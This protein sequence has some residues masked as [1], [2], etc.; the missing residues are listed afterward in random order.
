MEEGLNHAD[1]F[2]HKGLKMLYEG[3]R[4]YTVNITYTTTF[5]MMQ[6]CFDSFIFTTNASIYIYPSITYPCID[7]YIYIHPSP[8][9]ALFHIYIY[10]SNYFHLSIYSCINLSIHSFIYFFIL[11]SW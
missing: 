11:Y 6:I 9:R 2:H 7:S 1:L 10:P 4:R 5:V 8:T 3:R